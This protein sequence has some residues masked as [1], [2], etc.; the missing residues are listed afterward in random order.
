MRKRAFT[1]VEMMIVV[2]IIGLLAALAIPLY[3]KVRQ[4]TVKTTVI[5]DAVELAGAAQR[6]YLDKGATAV[7]VSVLVNSTNG[8]LNQL[9]GSNSINTASFDADSA[10]TFEMGNPILVSGGL[11]FDSEGRVIGNPY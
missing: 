1:L 3:Q 7:A 8:Y 4:S 10:F 9:S 5:S 2:V 11:T 6:Y